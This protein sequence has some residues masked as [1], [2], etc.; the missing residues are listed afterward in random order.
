M[1]TCR[2]VLH[3]HSTS[4]TQWFACHV[5]QW[6][7]P[8]FGTDSLR[9]TCTCGTFLHLHPTCGTRRLA[10]HLLP[11]GFNQFKLK[12]TMRPRSRTRDQD[13]GVDHLHHYARHLVMLT[14]LWSPNSSICRL[15]GY[16]DLY[17]YILDVSPTSGN[18]SVPVGL[19]VAA[20]E[21]PWCAMV[22]QASFWRLGG[23]SSQWR[24]AALASVS[25]VCH[26]RG[27]KS[28]PQVSFLVFSWSLHCFGPCLN[29]RYTINIV[30]LQIWLG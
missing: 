14:C 19:V 29:M 18:K 15:C 30:A 12:K 9:V 6:D 21:D 24:A 4:G 28:N 7:D 5:Y 2:T 22:A 20:K 3:L 11:L 16:V 1:C 13:Q 10:C 27:D 25:V 23:G 8:T 17:S 26:G